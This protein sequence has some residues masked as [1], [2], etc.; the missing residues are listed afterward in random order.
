MSESEDP[1]IVIIGC[2]L[3]GVSAAHKLVKAG[4]HNVQILEATGRSGGR[5]HTDRLGER[6]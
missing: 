6:H 1:K 3:S 5:I 4:F 2:G